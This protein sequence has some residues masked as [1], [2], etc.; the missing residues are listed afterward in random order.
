MKKVYFSLFLGVFLISNSNAKTVDFR[1]DIFST[2]VIKKQDV[3]RDKCDII[4]DNS[5]KDIIDHGGTH[6]EAVAISSAA[7]CACRDLKVK[8]VTFN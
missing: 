3:I 5:Y 6:E 2:K 4:Y 8:T 1:E 7:R